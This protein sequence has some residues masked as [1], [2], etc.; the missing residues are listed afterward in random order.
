MKGLPQIDSRNLAEVRVGIDGALS[1]GFGMKG[2]IGEQAVT[3]ADGV[4]YVETKTV[5][6]ALLVVQNLPATVFL[7]CG[8]SSMKRSECLFYSDYLALF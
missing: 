5:L 7:S 3:G 2:K 6:Q 1:N 8:N 4:S